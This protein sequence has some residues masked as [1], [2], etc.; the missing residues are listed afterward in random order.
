[1]YIRFRALTRNITNK[2]PQIVAAAVAAQLVHANQLAERL[3][4]YPPPKVPTTYERT[5]DLGRAWE[6][7]GPRITGSGVITSI[8]NSMYYAEWVQGDEQQEQHE[9]TGWLKANDAT[10]REVYAKRLQQAINKVL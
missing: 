7:H 8:V 9:E 2:G 6:V 3:R 4:E 5:G 10:E 1:M